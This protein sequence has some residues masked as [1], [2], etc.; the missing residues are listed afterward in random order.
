TTLATGIYTLTV[1]DNGCSNQDT[2]SVTVY[3]TPSITSYTTDAAN[4]TI[5]NGS[6]VQLIAAVNPPS[7]TL[8]WSGPNGYTAAAPPNPVITPSVTGTYTVVATVMPGG[9]QNTGLDT[10]RVTVNQ[11]PTVTASVNGSSTI[12]SGNAINLLGNPSGYASYSWSGPLSYT[13]NLQNPQIAN[14]TTGAYTF[15][16]TVINN[17]C[18]GQDTANV[19]VNPTP[20][21]TS[22]TTD[23]N[24]NT[25]CLGQNIQLIAT[26]NPATAQI[27]WTGPN[28]FTATAPPNPVITPTVSGTYTVIA[29][30]LPPAICQ[31][32]GVDTVHITV[33]PKPV[34]TATNSTTNYTICS[35]NN[36][37][38]IGGANGN[39]YQWN[40]PGAYSS[41]AQS[42]QITNVQQA[43]TGTYTLTVSNSFSC[44]SSDTTSFNV[45]LTPLPAISSGNVKTCTGGAL[46]VSATGAGTL[47]WYSGAALTNLVFTGTTFNP[48][49]PS[50]TTNIYYVTVTSSSNCQS[51]TPTMV[52]VGNY[53]IHDTAI[54]NVYSGNAPLTV[55][56]SGQIFGATN[57]AYS[58]ALGDAATSTLQNPSHTYNAGGDYIVTLISTDTVSHCP[59]TA[60]LTIHVIDEMIVVIPNI[61]TPNGDGINDGFFVT[62]TG[63]KS[64]EGFIMNR[65]GQLMFEWAGL[66]SVWNGTAPNGNAETEGTYFYVIKVTSFSNKT[67]EFKGP[68]TLI[69]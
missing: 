3:Q 56:F 21:I 30:T 46:T 41:I 6:N 24:K 69:R 50:G 7:A 14:S 62:T 13:S 40:G 43:Q 16:L 48:T 36:V 20:S 67:K 2:A 5:C 59:A 1:T 35:G 64:I 52:S 32:T 27:I 61:F 15:T 4:N 45:G 68:L 57:P 23:A 18:P 28:G 53:N 66:N 11:V 31:S 38:L 34:A 47:N 17:G 8:Q 25:I 12:C 9:C 55:N 49:V 22:D 39:S 44:T 10:V 65:W 51:T 54:A 58:W 60:T 26:A 37:T 29:V 33:N 63:V 19:F 42:P